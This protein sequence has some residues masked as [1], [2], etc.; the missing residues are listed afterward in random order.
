MLLKCL[1]LLHKVFNEELT[2]HGISFPPKL[3]RE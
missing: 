1:L 3:T 2:G